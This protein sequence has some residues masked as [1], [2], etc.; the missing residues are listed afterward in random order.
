MT[1]PERVRI[2]PQTSRCRRGTPHHKA[3]AAILTDDESHE[4][5]SDRS[6]VKFKSAMMTLPA[7]V[8]D[9]IFPQVRCCFCCCCLFVC[10]FFTA[11]L[12][13][14][15]M[16]VWMC[17]RVYVCACVYVSALCI[18]V[19]VVVGVFLYECV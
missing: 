12:Y 19:S 4:V 15:C 11:N 13:L 18:C 2:D 14:C 10:F 16:H 7:G 17:L 6:T 1:G 9:V 5:V 3:T 8:R